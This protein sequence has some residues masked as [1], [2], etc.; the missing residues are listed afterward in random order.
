MIQTMTVK[1]IKAARGLLDWTQDDLARKSG[2]ALTTINNIERYIGTPRQFTMETL[3]HTFEREGVEFTEGPGVRLSEN[4]FNIEI[5]D[6]K[7][8]PARLL[9]DRVQTLKEL[10]GG[11]FVA[12]LGHHWHDYQD[13]IAEHAK[14]LRK[15]GATW[16]ALICIGDTN[17]NE[18]DEDC[19]R[20]I[21]RDLYAQMPYYV[22]GD[23]YAMVLWGELI[24]VIIIQNK[25]IAN[26]M[27]AQFDA[28]W[29][30]GKRPTKKG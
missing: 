10:G 17:Y 12:H 21:S 8:A 23:K 15:I 20:W 28:N 24:R 6:G 13:E 26:A 4:I 3:Q 11:E 9:A 19:Y 18:E 16:R 2:I 5:F 7:D 29:N 22:Y 25:I 14:E 30:A 1:Q 27:R